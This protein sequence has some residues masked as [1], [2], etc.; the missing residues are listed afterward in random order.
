MK[1][2]YDLSSEK[3]YAINN[4]IYREGELAENMYF[5]KSGEFAQKIGIVDESNTLLDEHINN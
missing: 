1:N 5:I 4:V 3:Q 2:L